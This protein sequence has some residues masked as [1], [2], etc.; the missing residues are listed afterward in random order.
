MMQPNGS[1]RMQRLLRTVGSLWFAAVLLSLLLFAMAC[2]T[3]FEST[4]GSE[5][6]LATYYHAWWFQMLLALL[7]VNILATL[8]VRY[9]FSRR[10]V[11]FVITHVSILLIFGGAL[12]TA[13]FGVDGTLALVEGESEH[14]VSVGGSTLTVLDEQ[15]GPRESLNLEPAVGNGF[16]PSAVS[17]APSSL[18]AVQLPVTHNPPVVEPSASRSPVPSMSSA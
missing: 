14:L 1:D 2:A 9:P 11:G 10:Q 8:I 6:T 18:G 7:G 12:L 3:V 4:H 16:Q 5:R 15:R 17:A 13:A